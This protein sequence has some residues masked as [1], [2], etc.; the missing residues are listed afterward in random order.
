MLQLLNVNTHCIRLIVHRAEKYSPTIIEDLKGQILFSKSGFFADMIP[1]DVEILS[2]ANDKVVRYP[3]HLSQEQF[4]DFIAAQ[5]SALPDAMREKLE[6]CYPRNSVRK[7]ASIAFPVI[8]D[9]SLTDERVM[10]LI[11]AIEA[12]NAN[13]ELVKNAVAALEN[14]GVLRIPQVGRFMPMYHQPRDTTPARMQHVEVLS[15][16]WVRDGRV[17]RKSLVV[18]KKR[19]TE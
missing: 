18:L 4:S 15:D 3:W 14:K 6:K 2:F 5:I 19:E 12:D 1:S 10:E 16:G 9:T 7:I 17:L 8:G 13:P 11:G